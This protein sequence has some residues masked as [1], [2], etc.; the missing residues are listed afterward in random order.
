MQIVIATTRMDALKTF[1][2]ALC[3]KAGADLVR[4]GS[5]AE[6]LEKVREAAPALVVVDEN[7][8]DFKAFALVSELLMVNAMIN[9]ATVSSLS[10]ADFHEASEG[11]GI[12]APV[13]V[14]PGA[15]DGEKLAEI[16][17]G[18]TF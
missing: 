4:T 10:D 9:T 8:P 11:L 2:E 17:E 13:P 5:G 15:A 18:V 14:N 6:T 12:L 3:A 16:L 7:L 1:A